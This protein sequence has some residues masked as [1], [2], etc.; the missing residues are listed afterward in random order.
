[1]AK[2]SFGKRFILCLT[3]TLLL[4]SCSHNPL[5]IDVS[6]MNVP[7]VQIQ[8][9]EK[10]MFSMPPDSINRY[11]PVLIKKYGKFYVDF[12]T[13]FINNGGVIDSTYTYML[14]KFITDKDMRGTYDTCKK[15][16]PDMNTLETGLTDAFK[17]FKYY[18]PDKPLPKVLTEISGYQYSIIY[19][20]STLSISLDMYLGKNS[21][22]YKMLQFPRFKTQHMSKD[23]LL[24]DAVY[25]WLASIYKPN[26]DRPD[27]LATIIH[28]GKIMYLE[29]AVLPDMDD[30]MKIRYSMKQLNWCRQNEFNLW[31]YII[32]EKLLYSTAHNDIVR[33]TDD[34][35][36]TSG[37]NRDFCPSRTGS[38]LG[39]QIVRS[40]MKKND[41]VTLQQ[42][43]EE[44]SADNILQRSGYKPEK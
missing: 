29:D 40:Y 6:N 8:R 44:K 1:M 38:W 36:F 3:G 17:H 34:G 43:M 26:E 22:F 11:T 31:A 30:T 12:V 35:P 13:G 16:Y 5:K 10:D 33:F 28:E 41:G 20:D 4:A 25:G 23:Y 14:K 15:I 42:L 21:G 27:L 32:K 24:G 18:F 37:F 2:Q 9:L 7:A 39:W 19:Y